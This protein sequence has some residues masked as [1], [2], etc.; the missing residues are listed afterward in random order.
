MDM[1]RKRGSQ[2]EMGLY[3]QKYCQ[4][5]ALRNKDEMQQ[6]CWTL[7]IPQTAPLGCICTLSSRKEKNDPEVIQR[8]SGCLH[9]GFEVRWGFKNRSS[10]HHPKPLGAG[11][12]GQGLEQGKTP[13]S[14]AMFPCL[15]PYVWPG[16]QSTEPKR[17]PM[18]PKLND[19]SLLGFRLPRD[20]RRPVGLKQSE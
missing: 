12:P 1:N 11:S 19:S 8:S 20:P 5:Q 14:G 13:P 16:R 3:Q 15:E 4:N 6:G 7:W 10:C 18:S 2:E 9:L 17:K